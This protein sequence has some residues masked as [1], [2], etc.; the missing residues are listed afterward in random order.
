MSKVIMPETVLGRPAGSPFLLSSS[1]WVDSTSAPKVAE[2]LLSYLGARRGPTSP[3][4]A[5]A[6]SCIPTGCETYTYRFR[7]Q[8]APIL[9]TSWRRSLILRIYSSPHGLSRARSEFVAQHHLRRLGYP[10]AEPL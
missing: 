4:F 5:E 1:T 7:L 3:L 10:V 6:P 9:P 8:A 2:S